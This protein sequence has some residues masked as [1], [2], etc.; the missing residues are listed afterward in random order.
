MQKFTINLI[1]YSS[2]LMYSIN[3]TSYCAVEAASNESPIGNLTLYLS[4]FARV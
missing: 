3:S 4:D 2:N 1:G